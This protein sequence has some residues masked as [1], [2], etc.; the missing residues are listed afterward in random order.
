MRYPIVIEAGSDTTAYG[1]VVP[2]LPGC[3]SAGD[4][5]DEAVTNAEQ[6][7][8]AW[9]ETALDHGQEIPA[10]S[11]LEQ[12]GEMDE[13]R[14]WALG[15]VA[16]DPAVLDNTIERV[17]ITIPRRLLY[18]LDQRV[19]VCNLTVILFLSND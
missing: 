12:V 6:A 17:N 13:Y 14:G 10:P 11:P 15:V 4:T 5:M 16:V 2:D 18:R 7:A 1:V 9:I 8:I 3:F 19:T